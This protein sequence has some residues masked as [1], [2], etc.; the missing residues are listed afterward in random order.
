MLNTI[1]GI[2]DGITSVLYPKRCI[3]CDKVLLKMEKEHGFCR[4]CSRKVSLVGSNYCLKC[5]Q[6]I[7]RK[8]KELCERCQV[9]KHNF[10]QV[11]A[12]YKYEGDMKQAIYRF[13]YGN[14]RCYAKVFAKHA[15]KY[16]GEWIKRNKIEAIIPVPMYKPKE[17]K[18]GY[19]Q[20]TVFARELSVITGIPMMDDV[21]RR[22][23]DTVAMKQLIGIKRTK[24]LLNV[25]TLTL[26][27]VQFRK[28][29]IVD[30]IYT[31]GTT[32]DEVTKVLKQGGVTDV[33]GICVCIGQMH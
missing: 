12:L 23:T 4:A 8:L 18:R 31:T 33:F 22:N 6:P 10:N 17:K 29:L 11:R 25:F 21:V 19:N 13:K 26:K 30:D 7:D 28:V 9:K 15:V 32:I 20:A 3:A 2:I 24:N 14:R 16:Y 5:G 27:D 1:R